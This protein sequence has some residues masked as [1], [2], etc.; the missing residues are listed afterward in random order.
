MTN[1]EFIESIRLEGEEW[2][3]VVGWEDAYMVSSLGRVVA[4][5]RTMYKKNRYGKY[6]VFVNKPHLCKTFVSDK[7]RYERIVLC[8]NYCYVGKSVHRMVAE[9]F[10]PNP[11]NYPQ[12]D[13]I[14]DKPSD[15]MAC[16]LQW[17]TAKENS[18][19]QSHRIALSKSH[20][21]KPNPRKK[22]IVSIDH[23]GKVVYY[24]SFAEAEKHNHIRSA[25]RKV[26]RGQSKEHH[27]LKWM[28][29][30]DYEK[31]LTNHDVKELS[32]DA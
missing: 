21:G 5:E 27:G 29:L 12:I 4:L 15:N 32:T 6:N 7:Y 14:N 8:K 9:A 16:N 13:H 17:C 1:Q 31:T 20:I 24:L 10:I 2:R 3:P 18:T 22:P 26:I 30:S 28:Y 25:I 19:K 11:H 23:N